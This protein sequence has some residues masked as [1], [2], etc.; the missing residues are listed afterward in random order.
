MNVLNGQLKDHGVSIDN[1]GL[2]INSRL[3]ANAF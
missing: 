1:A 3:P 2:V